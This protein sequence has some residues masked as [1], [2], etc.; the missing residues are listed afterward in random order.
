MMLG[1]PRGGPGETTPNWITTSLPPINSEIL[2]WQW[3]EV[4]LPYWEKTV[5]EAKN[6]GIE[7]IALE[8]HGS[9]LVYNRETLMRLRDHVG[10]MVGMNFD[11]SHLFWMGGDPIMAVRSL[12]NAIYH[13]H[14]KDTRL[15]KGILET[16]GSLDTKS[17]HSFSNRSWNFAA[18]GY[19]TM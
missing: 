17:V 7:K 14:A 10:E 13:V 9:Q 16:E 2:N 3:E 11:P 18:I 8:N 6:H 12:G 5:Q 15:E 19:A 1:L 4:A